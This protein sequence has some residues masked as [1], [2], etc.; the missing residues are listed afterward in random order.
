MTLSDREKGIL[1]FIE[2]FCVRDKSSS[3]TIREIMAGCEVSSTSVVSYHLKKL[4]SAGKIYI[5]PEI[6]RGIRLVRDEP[7]M[8]VVA[9]TDSTWRSVR[10]MESKYA[11][12]AQGIL[13]A[14]NGRSGTLYFKTDQKETGND[15]R[16]LI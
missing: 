11:V 1:A 3:P 9:H 16:N 7:E 12:M 15:D 4:E 13:V 8:E 5:I 2:D 6:S 14:I 10:F